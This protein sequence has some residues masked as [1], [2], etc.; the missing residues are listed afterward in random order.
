MRGSVPRRSGVSRIT[1]AL[2]VSL[3]ALTN[4]TSEA[5]EPLPKRGSYAGVLGWYVNTGETVTVSKDHV[6]WGGVS[7]GAF[8][9]DLYWLG[10]FCSWL[11]S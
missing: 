9:N 3:V 10:A 5:A 1:A 4:I 8:R 7:S 11:R 2:A 6:V